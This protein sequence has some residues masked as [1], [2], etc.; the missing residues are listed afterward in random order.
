MMLKIGLDNAREYPGCILI[1]M[2]EA[3]YIP[4]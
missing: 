3:N 1:G 4:F 2:G